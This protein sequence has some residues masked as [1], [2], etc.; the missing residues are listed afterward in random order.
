[1]SYTEFKAVNAVA[2][3]TAQHAYI[4]DS[5]SNGIF[6]ANGAVREVLDDSF[7]L[8]RNT[9]V[10]KHGAKLGEKAITEALTAIG[11]I[12]NSERALLFFQIPYFS[13][14]ANGN[15]DTIIEKSLCGRVLQLAL[16]VTESC[17]L[18]CKYCVYSG[19]YPGRRAH[20]TSHNI[21]I[22]LAKL[23]VDFFS[24]HS[25]DSEERYL[26]LYGGEPFLR[27][28]F[29]KAI[30]EYARNVCPGIHIAITSNATLLDETIIRFLSDNNIALTL[31]LDGPKE[32]HDRYRVRQNGQGSFDSVV[33]NLGLIKSKFPDFYSRK[34]KINS[35]V[36]PYDG[37][38]EDID[39]FFDKPLLEFVKG[40]QKYSLGLVNPQSNRFVEE[41]DYTTY[42]GKY[43]SDRL[44]RFLRNNSPQEESHV[45]IKAVFLKQMK[46][47]RIRSLRKLDEYD[48]YWPNGICIPGVRSL[49]VSADGTFYPCEKLY[50]YSDMSIGNIY[51][52]F[53][54]KAVRDYVSQ[55]CSRVFE[56][57]SKCWAYRLCGECFLSI[58][59][60]GCWNDAKRKEFCAGQKAM[61]VA[62]LTI[63]TSIME[64]NSGAFDYLLNEDA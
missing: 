11:D 36:V 61:W 52:G 54:V 22:G 27:F 63:Y 33:E 47:L 55:Y 8:P 34:L 50:D 20:N 31:S 5:F 1:M 40:P 35:V 28:G 3:E 21:S 12:Q 56:Y 7:S 18:R 29:V 45:T 48:F 2:F 26:S 62:M 44:A 4:Y 15:E 9:I 10:E 25:R 43:Y 57:C 41:N 30:V 24:K 13:L 46:M 60:H 23:A 64:C 32:L 19:V 39:R 58:R 42:I 14:G 38:I 51:S 17:N 6:V 49:F 16:N 59:G 37:D 53:D